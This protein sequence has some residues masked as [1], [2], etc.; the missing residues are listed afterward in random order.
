[1]NFFNVVTKL[2][3]PTDRGMY[4]Y[5]LVERDT[6]LHLR[7][8]KSKDRIGLDWDVNHADMF[9]DDDNFVAAGFLL[10]KFNRL[11]VNGDSGNYPTDRRSA[12]TGLIRPS[13]MIGM[14]T[15]AKFAKN[16]AR[17]WW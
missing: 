15:A 8:A 2:D 3:F 10:Q 9:L 4:K 16:A 7:A 1:V 14:K 6:S 13:N 17:R 12:V 11:I 5:V